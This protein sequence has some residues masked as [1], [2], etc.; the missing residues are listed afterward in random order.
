M[1]LRTK[2][3]P[4]FVLLALATVLHAGC[5][6][7]RGPCYNPNDV[8]DVER[9][10]DK[11]ESRSA[12]IGLRSGE[13][14]IGRSVRFGDAHCSWDTPRAR[15]R[16]NQDVETVAVPVTTI[17]FVSLKEAGAGARTGAKIG[18]PLLC[19]GALLESIYSKDLD[20][21]FIDMRGIF[22]AAGAFSFGIATG[23]GALLG[24]WVDYPIDVNCEGGVPGEPPD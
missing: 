9:L 14:R 18:V 1:R 17:S 3:L 2:A 24:S 11:L 22:L 5:G 15:S 4:R 8:N 12:R 21:G 10:N 13:T 16:R 7:G 23:I 6:A 19:L 20:E